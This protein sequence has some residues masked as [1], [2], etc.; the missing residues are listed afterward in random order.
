MGTRSFEFVVGP[1]TSDL[2]ASA[3]PVTAT[4]ASPQLVTAGAGIV[5]TGN[6]FYEVI[7]VQGSG[8]PVDVTHNPQ[9]AVG[10][11]DGAL[12][13]VI[14][15]SD[16]NTLTLED[17]TGL[18]MDGDIVLQAGSVIMFVWDDAALLWRQVGG[19]TRG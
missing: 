13:V 10:E 1:E 15:T 17:G 2:P 16:V 4:F 8:G 6:A 5:P 12:L 14:G 19:K 11:I 18:S 9:I 7:Y 3:S